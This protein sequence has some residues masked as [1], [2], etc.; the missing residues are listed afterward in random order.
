[1]LIGPTLFTGKVTG[2]TMSGELDTAEY[3]KARWSAKRHIP[4]PGL[5]S[6]G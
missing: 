3:L 2:D 6:A 5:P 1:L 4:R